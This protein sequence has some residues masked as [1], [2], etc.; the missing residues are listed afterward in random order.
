MLNLTD[1]VATCI[2]TYEFH[3]SLLQYVNHV[4]VL[5]A[6]KILVPRIQT[7]LQL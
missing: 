1:L 3:C 7:R 2:I 5:T 6:V 4:N